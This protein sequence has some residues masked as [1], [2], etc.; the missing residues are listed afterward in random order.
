MQKLLRDR[1]INQRRMDVLVA[2]VRGQVWQHGLGVDSCPIPFRHSVNDE[3]VAKVVDAWACA[4][5]RTRWFYASAPQDASQQTLHRY[6]RV[7]APSLL[8][9][10]Q[11]RVVVGGATGFLP[12]VHVGPKRSKGAGRERQVPGLEEFRFPDL[13]HSLV[14]PNVSDPESRNLSQ[15]QPGAVCQ[16]QHRMQA[17]GTERCARRR[18]CE[19]SLK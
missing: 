16:H 3:C 15:A 19:R 8:M 2:E 9:P 5:A 14:D 13:D 6:P 12:R 10:K 17:A 4:A 7:S 18:E 1:Q 11:R